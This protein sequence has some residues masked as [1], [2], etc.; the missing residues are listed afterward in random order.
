MKIR[1]IL[2]CIISLFVADEAS[3]QELQPAEKHA[4]QAFV[5]DVKYGRKELV[6]SAMSY[7]IFRKYPL[8][9]VR[10]R[11]EFLNVY[12][13]FF[14]EELTG[15]LST[16]EW[17]RIGWRGIMC[18]NGTV[19]G[20]ID[21]N[22]EFRI[23]NFNY[24]TK[25]ERRHWSEYVEMQRSQLYP[26]LRGFECPLLVMDTGKFL[27]RIDR[28]PD[29]TIR[30]ASWSKGRKQSTK[31]DLVLNKGKFW[32]EGSMAIGYYKFVNYGYTYLISENCSDSCGYDLEILRDGQTVLRQPAAIVY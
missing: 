7:P 28:M 19:W 23:G 2:F 6:A 24:R 10:D 25:E 29:E 9:P 16:A 5:N 26:D 18:G 17:T 12:D 32:T 14:D 13:E 22:G 11:H 21:E 4:I 3:S 15:I 27:I 30:Y 8:P 1:N 20:E 31:P